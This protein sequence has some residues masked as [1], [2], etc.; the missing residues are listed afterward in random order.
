MSS[1]RFGKVLWDHDVRAGAVLKPFAW[2]CWWESKRQ[3][4][5]IIFTE[6]AEK[7]ASDKQSHLQ[8]H[9]SA[10]LDNFIIYLII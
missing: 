1:C 3:T 7:H 5:G 10:V 9:L 4:Y 8:V 2:W 6:L